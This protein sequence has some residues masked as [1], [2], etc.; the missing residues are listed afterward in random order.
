MRRLILLR[1]PLH[2]ALLVLAAFGALAPACRADGGRPTLFLL[3]IGVSRYEHADGDRLCNLPAA[4]A[5]ARA[6]AA[7]FAGQAGK[8]YGRVV[9]Q[10]LTDEQATRAGIERALTELRDRPIREGDYLVVTVAGHGSRDARG[11]Y[12]FLPHDFDPKRGAATALP[13]ATFHGALA[14][15]PGTRLLVLDTCRAGAARSEKAGGLVVFAACLAPEDSE[16]HRRLH[17]GVFTRALIEGLEGRAD[18]NGDGVVTL[19]EVNAYLA[20]RVPAL[21][22]GRQH[23]ATARPA[24]VPASLPLARLGAA[25]AGP[26]P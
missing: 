9:R 12:F 15:L 20:A 23:P 17:G 5:D 13:W 19:A 22:G 24:S 16:E 2:R 14:G 1:G 11:R 7:A 25:V 10:T 21:S 3:S 6:L 4:A 8:Q 26:S 18:A